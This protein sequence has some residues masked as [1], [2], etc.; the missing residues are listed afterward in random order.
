VVA[1]GDAVEEG[2]PVNPVR[3]AEC[4]YCG[5]RGPMSCRYV[6]R[7]DSVHM[8]C[9]GKCLRNW[10]LARKGLPSLGIVHEP[11]PEAA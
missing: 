2:E 4:E 6:H 11:G 10:E 1:Q 9:A 7:D 8:F 5:Q 3:I